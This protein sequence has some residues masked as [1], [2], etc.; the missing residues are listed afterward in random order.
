MPSHDRY[1]TIVLIFCIAAF[2]ALGI[3]INA[4]AFGSLDKSVAYWFQQQITPARTIFAFVITQV[5]SD[6]F[7]LAATAVIAL[8]LR[9]RYR[10]WYERLLIT[11]VGGM[12]L[13][14]ILKFIFYRQRPNF[15]HP[16]LH[17]YTNSFPSGHTVSATV[18]FGMVII[19]TP[20]FTP[21]RLVHIS[22]IAFGVIMIV[23]VAGSRIYLGVH[24]FSDIIGGLLE[25]IGWINGV[26]IMLDRK[27]AAST[28]LTRRYG[29]S[30]SS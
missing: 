30:G 7:T 23:L 12:I 11:V 9:K 5:G 14:E 27:Y 16:L 24:Y 22:V 21:S 19:L 3:S 8:Y 28:L 17:L 13:N 4:H 10:Y 26:G 1:R 2:I 15:F 6:A 25:G 29:T 20:L 18:L